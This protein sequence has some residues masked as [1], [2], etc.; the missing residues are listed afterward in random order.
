MSGKIDR[1]A[2]LKKARESADMERLYLAE[3]YFYIGK[4]LA[5]QGQ[6]AEARIWYERAVSL[7]ATPFREHSLAAYELKTQK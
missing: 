2:L 4:R 1:D 3:A 7:K 5:L 6:N